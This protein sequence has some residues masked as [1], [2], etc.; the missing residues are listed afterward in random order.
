MEKLAMIATAIL[1]MFGLLKKLRNDKT[2]LL[3]ALLTLVFGL[4]SLWIDSYL[5]SGTSKPFAL[6]SPFLYIIL[7]ALLRKLYKKLYEVEPT[8]Y[9]A[10][11]YD[12]EERRRQNW[13]DVIV[14]IMPGFI[15]ITFPIL[16]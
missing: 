4:S 2:L 7:Y 14:A 11:W 15:S 8:Y 5:F 12:P 1:W 13:L 16:I 3:L 6:L 9:R 10:S